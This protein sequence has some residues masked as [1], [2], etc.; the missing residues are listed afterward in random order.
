VTISF[1]SVVELS[2]TVEEPVMVRVVILIFEIL[3]YF[4][5]QNPRLV[6]LASKVVPASNKHGL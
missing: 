6:S 4:V 5:F 3:I 2:S 1:T